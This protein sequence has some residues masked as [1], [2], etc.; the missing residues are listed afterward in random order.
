MLKDEV[1]TRSYMDSIVKNKHL[2]KDKVVL[3]VGCGTGILSMFCA[4][5]GAKKVIGVDFSAIIEQA[6]EIVEINGLSDVVTLVR[7]KVEEIELPDGIEKVDIIVS[8][9]MGYC[10]LYESMLDTV[11]VARD[12]WLAEDGMLFPDKATMHVAAIEDAEYMSEKIDFWNSVYGFDMSPI[13]KLAMLEPLVDTVDAGQ[14][15]S[16]NCQ[17][18]ELD[19]AKV[20]VEDL[21]FKVPFEVTFTRDDY[22]HAIVCHF[23]IV[24][25]HCHKPVEFSTGPAAEYT[26][27]KQTVFYL[28]Q[29]LVVKEGEK[30]KGTFDCRPNGKNHRD[31]DVTMKYEF[32]GELGEANFEQEYRLR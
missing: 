17:I 8:E 12:K 2:F 26:H 4:K 13:R 11:L 28:K 5:A 16:T 18:L 21:A 22:C 29:S 7:G 27:W 25:G 23:D 15:I 9:W 14:L 3:D 6:R 20:K 31:L 24:F 32:K 30:L 1:R 10:L 19:I